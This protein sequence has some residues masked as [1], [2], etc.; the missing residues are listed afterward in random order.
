MALAVMQ[1]RKF[2]VLCNFLWSYFYSYLYLNI[3]HAQKRSAKIINQ[4]LECGFYRI[5]IL[6]FEF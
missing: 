2:K 6:N 3:E 1:N 5:S 4:I